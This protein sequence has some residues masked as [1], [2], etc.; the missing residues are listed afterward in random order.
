MITQEST[1]SLLEVPVLEALQRRH[2]DVKIGSGGSGNNAGGLGGGLA[3]PRSPEL[4]RHSDVSPASLKEIEKVSISSA[5]AIRTSKPWRIYVGF[6]EL[7]NELL[8]PFT[9]FV[10]L[11]LQT[12]SSLFPR[13]NRLRF[14]LLV[15]QKFLL[16]IL[17]KI[18][19]PL[20]TF[21]GKLHLKFQNRLNGKIA[22][23][24]IWQR[25][26]KFKI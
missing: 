1:D 11:P 4:R 20:W 17:C 14:F 7:I 3:P 24:I 15:P 22:Y 10:I 12:F 19:L 25:K 18:F 6:V 2:S 26:K 23:V 21:K 8:L 16:Y 13:I 5:N 9:A